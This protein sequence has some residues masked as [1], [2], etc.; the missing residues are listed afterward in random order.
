MGRGQHCGSAS[1]E[2]GEVVCAVEGEWGAVFE[3]RVRT[4]CPWLCAGAT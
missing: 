1:A 4:S 3:D 2:R